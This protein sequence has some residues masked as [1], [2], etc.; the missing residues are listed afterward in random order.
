[1]LLISGI[2]LIL[3]CMIFIIILSFGPVVIWS[4]LIIALYVMA[5]FMWI[6]LFNV[7]S[8]YMITKAETTYKKKTLR[9]YILAIS[10]T[11]VGMWF[12][13]GIGGLIASS[14]GTNFRSFFFQNIWISIPIG[15]IIG[16]IIVGIAYALRRNRGLLS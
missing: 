16:P 7:P 3:P 13:L 1:M 12:Y 8:V 5:I 6:L 11:L 4:D 9:Y 2:L 10:A 15:F 14:A